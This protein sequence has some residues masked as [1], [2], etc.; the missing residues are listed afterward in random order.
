MGEPKSFAERMGEASQREDSGTSYEGPVRPRRARMIVT[1]AGPL[2]ERPKVLAVR[3]TE[4]Q[5]I[6][7]TARR[8]TPMKPPMAATAAAEAATAAE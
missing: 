4:P 3:P 7:G 5:V 2:T 6:D 8:V 1:E